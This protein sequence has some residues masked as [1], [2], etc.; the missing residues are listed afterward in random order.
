MSDSLRHHRR[1]ST[2]LPF[3]WDSPG[4]NTGVGFHFLLRCMKVK[5]E[6]EVAQ[7][8]PTSSDPMDCSPP[9]SSVHRIFQARILEWG[10]IVFSMWSLCFSLKKQK[11]TSIW[12]LYWG[13]NLTKEVKN[14]YAENH[15]TIKINCM[16]NKL[17][18]LAMN[19]W[20]FKKYTMIYKGVHP[21]PVLLP[22]KSH[23]W[24]S[25]VGCSSWGH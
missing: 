10:A 23:G 5:S 8:Y 14:L 25:L 13:I 6:S 19:T 7:L 24:R 4:K 18:V 11:V 16:L 9:G 21:T 17:T 2:R 20:T 3:P 22:G 15:K 12:V 1:Q